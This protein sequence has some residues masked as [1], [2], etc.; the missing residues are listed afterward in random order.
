MLNSP[1]SASIRAFGVCTVRN[2][3]IHARHF[4]SCLFLVHK[5]HDFPHWENILTNIILQIQTLPLYAFHATVFF[6]RHQSFPFSYRFS[7]QCA[8]TQ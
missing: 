7:V 1:A 5:P 4:N 3:R 2:K 8:L 6:T